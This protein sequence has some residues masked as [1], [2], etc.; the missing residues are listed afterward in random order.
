M[1]ETQQVRPGR[2]RNDNIF[3]DFNFPSP[4]LIFFCQYRPFRKP[5]KDI[6][7]PPPSTLPHD[8]HPDMRTYAVPSQLPPW[9]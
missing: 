5:V 1:R 9:V 6:V 7:S 2:C 4:G 3:R 8:S